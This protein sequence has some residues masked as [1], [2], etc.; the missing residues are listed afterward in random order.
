MKDR[1]GQQQELNKLE[2]PK[3]WGMSSKETTLRYDEFH[4]LIVLIFPFLNLFKR[5]KTITPEK[6]KKGPRILLFQRKILKYPPKQPQKIHRLLNRRKHCLFHFPK[7]WSCQRLIKPKI[8]KQF[9]KFMETRRTTFL[10]KV[11][12]RKNKLG[13][14]KTI[15]LFKEY[16]AVLQNKLPLKQKHPGSFTFP[17]VIRESF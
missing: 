14:F 17:Y 8:D 13:K 2:H 1:C 16:S 7:G 12:A 4:L 15:N 5:R 9:F 6:T 11:V 3:K 10:N